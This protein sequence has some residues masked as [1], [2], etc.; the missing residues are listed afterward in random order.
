MTADIS[1][2]RPVSKN[3]LSRIGAQNVSLL[4]ALVVLLAIF[5]ALRPDV[6]FTPR[7]LINIGLAVTILGILAM[8]QTVVIVSGG[9]DIS[10]GSIVGLSTMVLAVA[11]QETGSIPLGILACL[12]AGLL[13]GAVNGLIIV[14]GPVNAV[15]ATLG[16]MSAFRGLAYLMNNGNSIPIVGDGLRLLGTGT[17]LGLPFA[18][19]LL[20]AVMAAFIV[21]TRETIVGRNI[22]AMGGNPTVARLAGIAVRRYQVGIYAM[23]GCAAAVAGIVLAGRTMSGQPASGS[24]GLELE[25]ITAAILGGCALQ[26]GK[27]T[28][29]GAM[30][31]VLI[32]GVLNNGM[33][34]T[35]VPTFYQL[36]AKGA[37]LILAVIV[38][39][40]QRARTGE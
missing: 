20:I 7:N 39:E 19:W 21:F 38:Q 4:I 14:Y 40:R 27:G 3:W 16:T 11:V 15:I 37:L 1:S 25:A 24:Q 18:I 31:G 5:G 30:L 26:G 13:A 12:A 35:S 36:L 2:A 6:F 28:I 34:L 33:I 29:I 10:V 32:I 8:A 9:L 23:S 17:L 22:Y